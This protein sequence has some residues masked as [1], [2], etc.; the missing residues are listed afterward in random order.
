[1]TGILN[2]CNR[3]FKN[4]INLTQHLDYHACHIFV[5]Y[6]MYPYNRS[7]CTTRIGMH[8]DISNVSTRNSSCVFCHHIF[9]SQSLK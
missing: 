4:A 9:T 2:R 6:T 5:E 7:T 8:D 3:T 1:M